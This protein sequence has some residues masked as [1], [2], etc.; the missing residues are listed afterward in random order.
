[1]TVARS[2]L[3]SGGTYVP[4]ARFKWLHD[5]IP[6]RVKKDSSAVGKLKRFQ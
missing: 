3:G 5:L 4:E 1:V 6:T 2:F